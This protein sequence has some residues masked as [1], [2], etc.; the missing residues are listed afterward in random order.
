MEL[1]GRPLLSYVLS[2]LLSSRYIDKIFVVGNELP[3]PEDERI[4][5]IPEGKNFIEN[6]MR[7]I[8][9]CQGEFVL[10]SS[11]DL[12]FLTPSSID[13]FIEKALPLQADFAYPTV[14]KEVFEKKAPDI[15]KTFVVLKEGKFAGGNVVLLNR[16][17]VLKRRPI[18]EKA[19]EVRKSP[20]K[21]AFFLGLEFFLR[22]LLQQLGIPV[23]PLNQV[24]RLMS[25]ALKG[26]IRSVLVDY[27]HLSADV[28]DEKDL[29]WALERLKYSPPI[30]E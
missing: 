29:K 30:F 18:I 21:I 22:F 11:A 17:F 20:I 12:P 28:D 24:E 23:L 26:K 15:D 10:V 13:K 27:P 1:K 9:K 6:M 8:E 7:G 5:P 3:L 4:V 19:Y 14:S 25:R 16:E 2:A